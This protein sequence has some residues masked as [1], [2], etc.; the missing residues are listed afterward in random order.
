ME[1]V[2]ETLKRLREK[3]GWT[4]EGL[5]ERI[6]ID[7]A[8]YARYESGEEEPPLDTCIYLCVV[9]D[10]YPGELLGWEKK[11]EETG[12]FM[13]AQRLREARRRKGVTQAWMAE[14]LHIHRTTYTKY[15]TAQAEPPL[16]V[17]YR[18]V[19]V[20]DVNPMDLLE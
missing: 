3:K 9:L 14:R 6:H 7:P 16:E 10:S 20:L 13:F 5:A 12:T 1:I 17:F 4:Q 15:E 11:E 8:A 2:C 18:L 19:K